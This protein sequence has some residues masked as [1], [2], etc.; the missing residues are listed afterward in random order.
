MREFISI[1]KSYHIDYIFLLNRYVLCEVR[2]NGEKIV[3]NEDISINTNLSING[4]FFFSPADQLGAIIPLLE[5]EGPV[6]GTYRILEMFESRIIAYV[7][8]LYDWGLF[9]AVHPYELIYQVFSRHKFNKITANLDL[10]MRRFNE[11]QYWVC[12]ELCLCQNIDKR[13]S[14]LRKFIKT[15]SYCKGGCLKK[16]RIVFQQF[17]T[18]IKPV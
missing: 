8:T 15:A 5:Q 3:F 1:F 12:T 6:K 14:L 7:M 13:V 9:N 11:V 18:W 17:F 2:S 16:F 10:F 4:R